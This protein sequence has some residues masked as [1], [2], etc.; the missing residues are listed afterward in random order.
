MR[1]T[2]EIKEF[3]WDLELLPLS[4]IKSEYITYIFT[5]RYQAP[6]INAHISR[7]LQGARV[8]CQYNSWSVHFGQIGG[9]VEVEGGAEGS[10][11]D[12]QE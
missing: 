10:L 1:P 8:Y 3:K 4:S 6:Y 12:S 5:N 7:I 9:D 2:A 11:S